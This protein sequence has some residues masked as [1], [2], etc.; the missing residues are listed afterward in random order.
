MEQ[1]PPINREF[2]KLM[3]LVSQSKNKTTDE[4]EVEYLNWLETKLESLIIE[5]NRFLD[6]E[7]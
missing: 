3:M 1:F 2:D 7:Y 4:N 5:E 6:E